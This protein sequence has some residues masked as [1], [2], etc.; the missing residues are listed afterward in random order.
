MAREGFD[1]SALT[2]PASQA[3]AAQASD[4][5]LDLDCYDLDVNFTVIVGLED[6]HDDV[7]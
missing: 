7:R 4:F 3:Q 5:V 6:R 2:A 1:Q